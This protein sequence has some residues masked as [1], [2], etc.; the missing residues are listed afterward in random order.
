MAG[1][2]APAP[3]GLS[4]GQWLIAP[5]LPPQ[6]DTH[7]YGIHRTPPH[8]FTQ[9]GG[10]ATHL[11]YSDMSD[12]DSVAPPLVARKYALRASSSPSKSSSHQRSAA[13]AE[14]APP[15][16]GASSRDTSGDNAEKHPRSLSPPPPREAGIS[17]R[18]PRPTPLATAPQRDEPRGG[19]GGAAIVAN[20]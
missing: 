18:S 5:A 1:G 14:G 6:T 20:V 9:A 13:E 11:R 3:H 7:P 12:S 19:A 8:I 10:A 16:L 2:W 15:P 17:R 4:D